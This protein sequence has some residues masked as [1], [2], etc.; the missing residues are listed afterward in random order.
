MPSHAR[1]NVQIAVA[2]LTCGLVPLLNGCAEKQVHAA[3]P[4]SPVPT[5][6]VRPMTTAPDTDAAPPPENAS[7]A[8]PTLPPTVMSAPP[9]VAI[10]AEK[11]PA[12]RKP[13]V[14]QSSAEADSTPSHGPVPQIS[15]QLSPT[16]A[17]A[18]QRKTGEDIAVAEGN[19]RQTNGKR[20]NAAQSDLTEK[21]RSVLAQA[22]DAS[23]DGDWAR[24]Q[25]LAQ[26]DRVLSAE[27]ISSL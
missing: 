20:L 2:L 8:P 13:A 10:P 6:A 4:I 18:Y 17:A 9:P 14:E 22:R 15:P 12:P 3:A 5:E 16:D 27:L 19:L 24:A 1:R 23:R 11:P 7:I 25:K 21:I 26:K